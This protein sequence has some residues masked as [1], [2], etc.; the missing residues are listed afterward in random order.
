M[1]SSDFSNALP[2]FHLQ[3]AS[4]FWWTGSSLSISSYLM[5]NLFDRE[6]CTRRIRLRCPGLSIACPL[7]IHSWTRRMVT[8][9]WSNR[10]IRFI[11]WTR[12]STVRYWCRLWHSSI[13]FH[14]PSRLWHSIGKYT[15][16]IIVEVRYLW[17]NFVAFSVKVSNIA[18][19]Y[20][21]PISRI[22]LDL[23]CG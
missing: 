11:S 20:R 16:I 5:R 18:W 4:I 17:R 22:W 15:T 23:L 1:S 10:L 8:Q 13:V 21:G 19:A 2:W 14:A 7:L 3:F 6:L 9:I 12:H